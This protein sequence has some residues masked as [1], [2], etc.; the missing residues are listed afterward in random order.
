MN[1]DGNTP[2]LPDV[3]MRELGFT[4]R[5]DTRWYLC[6]RVGKFG[7]TLDVTIDKASGNFEEYV[8]DNDFLQPFYYG[9]A[10]PELRDEII[11][12]ID[13]II[14]ELN[15]AGLTVHVDH[16]AYGVAEPIQQ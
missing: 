16:G 10:K 9:R 3:K 12:N 4:D 13:R 15:E 6:K 7:I 11:Q 5:V 8:I 1:I 14:A 2:V